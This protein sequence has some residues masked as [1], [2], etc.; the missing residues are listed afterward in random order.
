M[1]QIMLIKKLI[2]KILIIL[3][4]NPKSSELKKYTFLVLMI[5]AKLMSLLVINVYE[6]VNQV[7]IPTSCRY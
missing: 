4:L 5:R 6:L 3:S 2:Y 7:V 1:S